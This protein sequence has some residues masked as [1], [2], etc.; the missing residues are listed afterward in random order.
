MQRKLI[1]LVTALL[2]I[3]SGTGTQAMAAATAKVQLLPVNDYLELPYLNDSGKKIQ[4]RGYKNFELDWSAAIT[5]AWEF[6]L[7]GDRL[8]LL[9]SK[10]TKAISKSNGRKL[11]EHNYNDSK[12]NFLYGWGQS[13]NGT[14]FTIRKGIMDDTID[15]RVDLITGGGKVKSTYF[16]PND[17]YIFPEFIAK[18]AMDSNDN[19][20]TVASGRLVSLSPNGS[21]N[22]A[23]SE[24]GDWKT[25]TT[26][27]GDFVF[28]RYETNIK[29]LIVDSQD[30]VLVLTD[31]DYAYY[32]SNTGKIL[33]EKQL[34]GTPKDWS[35][36]GYIQKTGQWIRAFGNQSAYI[37]ILDLKSGNLTKVNK[38]STAQLDLVMAKAGNDRYY[39]QSK[40]GITQIDSAGKTIW[41]Y[42]LRLNGYYTVYSMLCDSKGNVYIEDNGGSV[43][44]LDPAGKERF[45]LIV[46]N[47]T[48]ILHNIA[49]DERGTLYLVDTKLGVLAIKPTKR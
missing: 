24:V 34:D 31:L 26:T 16:L 14:I 42:P 37:E 43:F 15:A 40:H 6:K 22:W 9:D 29:E 36:S 32:L 23:N 4:L 7:D 27:I 41:E 5:D 45:V 38:P 28:T 17:Q 48:S 11:W 30:N 47:K 33:W 10:F 2:L 1:Y 12:P 19:L 35:A 3:I 46:K 8:L 49:V 39:V 44:S 21:L 20:I 18:V 25:T 13:A